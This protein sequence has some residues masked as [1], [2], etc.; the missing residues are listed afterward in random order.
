MSRTV[1]Q[2]NTTQQADRGGHEPPL[3][4][5]APYPADTPAELPKRSWLEIAKDVKAEAKDDNVTL[6]S[7]GVAFYALLALVPGLI[8]MISVYG[9]VADPQ[10][11]ERQVVNALKAAPAEVRT[12]MSQQMSDI[13][14]GSNG[15]AVLAVVLGIVVALWSASSGVGNLI[16]ALNV[17]YDEEDTRGWIK[18]KL[19]ALA[20][21]LGAILFFVLAF[22]ALTVLPK[23][24]ANTGLGTP[25]R[26]AANIAAWA[27]L[28]V[29]LTVG[30]AVLYRYGPDRTEPKWSWTSPGAVLAI[31][32]WVVGSIVFSIYT[33]NFGKYNETYG[34]L[35][36]VV[37][38]ML[39]LFITSLA[40]VL[41]AELNAEAERRSTRSQA[42]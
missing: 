5:G 39:W 30:L 3:E 41:G 16:A 38:T 42:D 17:A 13:A 26:W 32:L 21:T 36:A 20:F 27:F 11:I 37:V 4:P 35:G 22:G 31:V 40:I 24:L 18:R 9:L 28:V 8:A 23:A 33:A 7:A 6:M 10:Q 25:G 2:R 29:G 34:S 12:M 1:Q 15:G 14:S 19:L